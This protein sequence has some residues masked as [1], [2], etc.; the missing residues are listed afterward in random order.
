MR[1][2]DYHEHALGMGAAA[3]A[4]A[5]VEVVFSEERRLYGAGTASSI[6]EA[7]FAAVLSAIARAAARGW[8][9]VPGSGERAMGA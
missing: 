9:P 1:V 5:Y 4:V 7:S 6:V 8:I 3:T 2:S